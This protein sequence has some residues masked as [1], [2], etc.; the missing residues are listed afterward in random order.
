ML[1]FPTDIWR[2]CVLSQ[3]VPRNLLMPPKTRVSLT[4][5]LQT[6]VS[7]QTKLGGGNTRFVSSP[8]NPASLQLWK[9]GNSFLM[10]SGTHSLEVLPV[11]TTPRW[12]PAAQGYFLCSEPFSGPLAFFFYSFCLSPPPS[13]THFLGSV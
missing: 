3:Y 13:A 10:I 1:Y 11:L 9:A 5:S 4:S 8:T 12:G 6:G 2:A 7:Q